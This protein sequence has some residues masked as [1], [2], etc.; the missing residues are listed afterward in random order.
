MQPI[1]AGCVVLLDRSETAN[2]PSELQSQTFQRTRSWT[3]SLWWDSLHTAVNLLQ[4]GKDNNKPSWVLAEIRNINLPQM[5]ALVLVQIDLPCI[6]IY[7]LYI[8]IYVYDIYIHVWVSHERVPR[9]TKRFHPGSVPSPTPVCGLHQTST[10]TLLNSVRS[11]PRVHIWFV[12]QTL[13]FKM[14]EEIQ[15]QQTKSALPSD[16][17][18]TS[19]KCNVYPFYPSVRSF[20]RGFYLCRS[21]FRS[22]PAGHVEWFFRIVS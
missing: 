20:V 19:L 9:P 5:Q 15:P 18:L 17:I 22:N 1:P 7:I 4:G 13:R 21:F 12:S 16:C 8:L 3:W 14:A 2:A 11:V 6:Y 10:A